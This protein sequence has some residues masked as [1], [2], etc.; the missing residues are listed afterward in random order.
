MII[1]IEGNI[2]A[3]K[4][5]L[6]RLLREHGYNVF[7]EDV[8]DWIPLLNLTKE[9]ARR[10]IFTLHVK[11]LQSM[12]RMFDA[13]QGMN[14]VFV[15]RSHRSVCVFIENAKS[16]MTTE[17]IDTLDK[18]EKLLYWEP[19]V[20]IFL[21]VDTLV[22]KDRIIARN[23]ECESDCS[24]EYLQQIE[25]L[26]NIPNVISIDGNKPTKDIMTHVCRIISTIPE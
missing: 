2:G 11:I 5:T 19:N 23:R 16:L 10:W 6:L 14:L 24:L 18:L 4:T 22:C 3:G 1:S 8:S 25:N 21:K 7:E 17:E 26:Y 13:C 20:Y 9:N 15:E 12:R